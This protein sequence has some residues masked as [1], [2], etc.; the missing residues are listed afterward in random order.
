MNQV[1]IIGATS[2]RNTLPV[3]RQV[4]HNIHVVLKEEFLLHRKHNLS[5]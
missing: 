2:L 4:L 5:D 3:K 1:R